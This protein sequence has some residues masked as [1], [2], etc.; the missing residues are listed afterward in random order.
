MGSTVIDLLRHGEP[1]G[2]RSFRGNGIDD[3]LSENGWR[4]MRSALSEDMAWQ[5]I[6]TS[7]M[8]R[9]RDF[10]EDLADRRGIPLRVEMDLREVGFGAWEGRTPED[11]LRDRPDEYAAFYKDPVNNRPSGAEPLP[12]FYQRVIRSF[13]RIQKDYQGQQLLLVTHAGVIRAVMTCIMQAPLASMYRLG[14][15]YAGFCRV[16]ISD[17]N[18]R[19]EKI[20]A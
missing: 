7:P 17:K 20:N 1:V 15:G 4:Q 11:I 12:D 19:I 14:I 6:V 13:E 18:T 9:C 2:G 3:P 8:R 10:A 5:A 16:R